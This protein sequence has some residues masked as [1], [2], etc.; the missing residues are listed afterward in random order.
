MQKLKIYISFA[1]VNLAK[2]KT[3]QKRRSESEF[4]DQRSKLWLAN[5]RKSLA[6]QSVI[7]ARMA[8][9]EAADS[10][11]PRFWIGEARATRV[12]REMLKGKNPTEGM[13][14]E[15][16]KMYDE[17]LRRVVE[18]RLANPEMNLGDA[19]FTVVN[20][21]APSSYLSWQRTKSL[22][23]EVKKQ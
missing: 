6:E 3:M 21:P 22:I 7:S 19:V 18:M 20:S 11:T 12:I 8:F 14:K 13:S 2:L 5:F 4:K 9:Q 1:L 23:E 10:P 16:K 17:I 15:R